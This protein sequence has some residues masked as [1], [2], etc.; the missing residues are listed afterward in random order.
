VGIK[1]GTQV[2]FRTKIVVEHHR[3]RKELEST[4]CTASHDGNPAKFL[5]NGELRPI[6]GDYLCHG[7]EQCAQLYWRLR[8]YSSRLCI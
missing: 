8:K 1:L 6:I 4:S 2:L 3:G 5:E 7:D